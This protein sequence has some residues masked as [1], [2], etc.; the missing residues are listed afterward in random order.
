MRFFAQNILRRNGDFSG[1][2]TRRAENFILGVDMHR[3]QATQNSSSR[4]CY[5]AGHVVERL[6]TG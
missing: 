2:F 6:L 1:P 5:Y 4:L 3:L